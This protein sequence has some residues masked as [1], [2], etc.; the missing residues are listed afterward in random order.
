MSTFSY[1]ILS[2]DEHNTHEVRLIV[3]G[4][5]WIGNDHLGL[6]PPDL[7]RQLTEGHE[8][9]LIIG[10]C[11][12][13]CM[14]CDDLIVDVRR[15]ATSVEW[16]GR[17]RMTVVFGVEY[18]DH[19]IGILIQDHSWESPG[20]TVERH[21]NVMFSGKVMDDGYGFDWSST[22]IKPGFIIMSFTKGSQQ[23]LLE[24]PWN[25]ESVA[26]ALTRGREFLRERFDG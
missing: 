26:S 10:I 18:Y 2:H 15:T 6:D 1:Q 22:R 14:G 24:F 25:G 13:G 5:D 8:G 12:C 9:R 21:L 7:V 17:D 3:D 20:R 4:L 19:Q 16:S 11:N 23:R